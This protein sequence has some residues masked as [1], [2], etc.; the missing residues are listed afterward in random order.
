MRTILA[1]STIIVGLEQQT[2]SPEPEAHINL[3]DDTAADAAAEISDGEKLDDT[4]ADSEIS[5]DSEELLGNALHVLFCK[6]VHHVYLCPINC[7]P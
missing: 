1:T 4:A 5:D 3:T 2:S 6:L 7:Q